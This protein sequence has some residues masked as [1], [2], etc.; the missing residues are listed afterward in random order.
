[1][2]LDTAGTIQN[3]A[4]FGSVNDELL[5]DLLIDESNSTWVLMGALEGVSGNKTMNGFGGMDSWIL[6]L[7]DTLGIQEELV[8]GGDRDETLSRMT[9]LPSKNSMAFA[10]STDS[11][12]SGNKSV[13]SN[14]Q[15]DRWV[16]ET[17]L[18]GKIVN[19]FGAG[20]SS[21][22]QAS[23]CFIHNITL[24]SFG[25]SSSDVSG[26]KTEPNKGGGD[27]WLAAFDVALST[28]NLERTNSPIVLYPNPAKSNLNVKGLFSPTAYQIYSVAGQL[29]SAGVTQSELSIS[30]LELGIYIIQ[31]FGHQPIKL[32]KE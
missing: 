19:Q 32:V 23:D 22:E 2:K 21:F 8:L 14:G 3:Q 26:D 16:V 1:M 6:K 11:D 5:S 7:N 15:T 28:N 25:S 13:A 17:D 27:V 24:V 12:I 29:F 4:V 31:F 18:E 20:G 30:E 9:Y 10:I